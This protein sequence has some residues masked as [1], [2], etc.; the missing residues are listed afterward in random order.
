MVLEDWGFL[1]ALVM[2][3]I[4]VI[5]VGFSEV[6]HLSPE[7]RLF[8]LILIFIGVGLVPYVTGSVVPFMVE[9]QIRRRHFNIIIIAIRKLDDTMIFNS[10]PKEV[11]R[12]NATIIV[13]GEDNRLSRF[14]QTVMT[15]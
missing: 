2:T 3:I 9:G 12:A 6:R 5:S 1:D 4:S 8:T 7:G 13:V 11:I 14:N 15:G 10:S